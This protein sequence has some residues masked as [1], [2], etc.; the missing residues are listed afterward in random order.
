[1]RL[2][3]LQPRIIRGDIEH[4]L[5]VIQRLVD[6]SKGDLLVLPEY[7]LTGSLALDL[8]A[9]VHDWAQRSADAKTRIK[10]PDGKYLLINSLVEIDTT[11]RNCC[12][13]LPLVESQIKLFPDKT[14]RNSGIL[15]GTEQ[16]IFELFDKRFKVIICSDIKEMDEIPTNGLDFLIFV[17]H[18]TENNFPRVM[19]L[20]KSVSKERKLPVLASS[21]VSDRNHGFSSFVNGNVIVSLSRQEG[22]LEVEIE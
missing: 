2:S 12:E 4:N 11:L 1:M 22:I 21:L 18:F 6:E 17:Y 13:L 9:D 7:A 14:E 16:K 3:L 5:K 8:E 10:I 15:P 20:V 19:P